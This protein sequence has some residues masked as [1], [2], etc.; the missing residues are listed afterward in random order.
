MGD[1]SKEHDAAHDAILEASEM[2]QSAT[3]VAQMRGALALERIA[4]VLEEQCK[5][6]G[7][8]EGI[9]RELGNIRKQGERQ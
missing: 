6:G 9:A 2:D 7:A 5:I 1:T 3:T 8:Y 4:T